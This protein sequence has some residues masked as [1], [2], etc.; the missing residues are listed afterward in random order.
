MFPS[1]AAA[2][3]ATQ[4]YVVQQPAVQNRNEA[5]QLAVQHQEVTQSQQVDQQQQVIQQQQGVQQHQMVQQQQQV[6]QQQPVVQQ[7]VTHQ[8]QVVQQQQVTQQQQVAAQNQ[9]LVN[10]QQVVQQHHVTQ[11]QQVVHHPQGVVN[12]QVVQHQQAQENQQQQIQQHHHQQQVQQLQQ[13]STIQQQQTQQYQKQQQQYVLQQGVNFVQQPVAVAVNQQQQQQQYVLDKQNVPVNITTHPPVDTSCQNKNNVVATQMQAG[14]QMYHQPTHAPQPAIQADLYS[15]K[16]EEG[17]QSSDGGNTEDLSGDGKKRRN[18]KRRDPNYYQNFYKNPA[19]YGSQENAYYADNESSSGSSGNTSEVPSTSQEVPDTVI[20]M[21]GWEREQ[22]LNY[23]QMAMNQA[24]EVPHAN[25][26]MQQQQAANRTSGMHHGYVAHQTYIQDGATLI[27][28]EHGQAIRTVPGLAS[29]HSPP[30]GLQHSAAA[31]AAAA[32][33]LQKSQQPCVM[34]ATSN[35]QN[36]LPSGQRT[37]Q[38]VSNQVM[39]NPVATDDGMNPSQTVPEVTPKKL[40]SIPTTGV[41]GSTPC[42]DNNTLNNMVMQQQD[43][44]PRDAMTTPVQ[45]NQANA[46][47]STATVSIPP[48]HTPSASADSD[49]ATNAQTLLN[50]SSPQTSS[51]ASATPGSSTPIASPMSTPVPSSPQPPAAISPPEATLTAATESETAQSSVSVEALTEST[52]DDFNPVEAGKVPAIAEVESAKPSA[53]VDDV[54]HTAPVNAPAVSAEPAP[55]PKP[56]SWASLFKSSSSAASPIVINSPYENSTNDAANI[57]GS[58]EQAKRAPV[59]A[60]EDPRA[61]EIAGKQ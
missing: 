10:N 52:Q 48:P 53:N 14:G 40:D 21:S 13:P 59:S 25:V 47:H 3:P 15:D 42:S 2:I 17:A 44:T 9:L 46:P 41:M 30:P 33:Q 60:D 6:T 39:S 58:E 38:P 50:V 7:Q 11:S 20:D 22:N 61:K 8:Q 55:A 1:T 4:L 45:T 12:Q 24:P 43:L 57:L 28:T 37:T 32:I 29:G 49:E 31:A 27:M 51:S 18:K 5:Q 54:K 36:V 56:T 19:L 16:P 26:H 23:P 34:P 35:V